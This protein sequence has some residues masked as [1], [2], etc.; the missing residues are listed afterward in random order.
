MQYKEEIEV[1]IDNELEDF[2]VEMVE[3]ALEKLNIRKDGEERGVELFM[4]K[5]L[6]DENQ[7]PE[8]FLFWE[9]LQQKKINYEVEALQISDFRVP[10]GKA[11]QDIIDLREVFRVFDTTSGP[12]NI[13]HDDILMQ[14]EYPIEA[15]FET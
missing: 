10:F 15:L 5:I 1:L 14:L 12:L 6:D 7:N 3:H 4:K 11:Q 2:V 9:I 13:L 8:S